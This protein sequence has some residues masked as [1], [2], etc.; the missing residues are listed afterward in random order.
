M[1]TKI[2]GR[3]LSS[4]ESHDLGQIIKDRAKVLKAHAEE[5]AAAC[6]ADF[7]KK[8]SSKFEFDKDDVWR[9]LADD[10]VQIIKKANEDIAAHALKKYGIPNEFAPF[11]HLSWSDRGQNQ[12][13]Q[14]RAELRRLAMSEI[15]AMKKAAI[16][17]IER[18]SLD[19]RTQVISMGV[20]SADGKMFLES[21][22]PVEEAMTTIDFAAI[23]KKM[24][25]GERL[26]LEHRR[27]QDY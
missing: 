2:E 6:L 4:K 21:L 15:D 5:Q 23:E 17:R 26:R 8:I 18:Q 22:A 14:R 3:K 9:K 13:G 25:E 16:T 12:T 27:R 1:T 10:A 11:L 24:K 7:E 19:L 20:L